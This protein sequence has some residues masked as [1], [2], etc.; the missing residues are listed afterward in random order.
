MLLS[1]CIWHQR[2]CKQ[3]WYWIFL[4]NLMSY[5]VIL[6]WKNYGQIFLEKTWWQCQN[7]KMQQICITEKPLTFNLLNILYT[8]RLL[9]CCVLVTACSLLHFMFFRDFIKNIMYI[10]EALSPVLDYCHFLKH[11]Q[12]RSWSLPVEKL[13]QIVN[14]TPTHL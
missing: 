13:Y 6:F 9:I 2:F 3:L 10:S 14:P 4:C 1:Y 7:W 8:K 12:C 5:L 11:F